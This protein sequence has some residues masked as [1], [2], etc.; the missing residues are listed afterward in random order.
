MKAIFETVM[1]YY[2]TILM[3]SVILDLVLGEPKGVFVKMHPV[4]VTGNIAF[5]LFRPS[6]K[7]FGIFLWFISVI[8]IT[9]IYYFVPRVLMVINTII[10]IIVYAYFLKLTFS[11]KL[12]RDY[13]RRIMRSIEVG[14]LDNARMLTQQI[15]RRNVWELDTTHLISAVIESLAESFVDGL[16][17]PL[18]YFALL[19]LPGALL[20]R[21]SNTMDSMVGYRGWP[22]E[23]VGWFS[24]KVDTAL[25]YMPARLSSII[26]LI[27]S[28]LVGLNWRGSITA[29]FHYHRSVRSVNSG[30]P[31]AS[32]AGALGVML[33]KVGA[34]RINDGMPGPDITRLRL[35]LRLF[36]VSVI[37]AL[38]ITLV[39]LI[40]RVF[41]I[42]LFI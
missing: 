7:L 9:I 22:Y 18:F 31:M 36:D 4:V 21:L 28:G 8:P 10:G 38:V 33:E 5:K 2:I 17:S 12:M 30:W 41:F 37:I 13:T 19:G 42:P 6:N 35:A 11:I 23:D 29:A 16:L 1:L 20:Q 39:L 24:A 32:F 25:N 15:V 14:D 3:T 26:I 40:F 34:Y 27:A